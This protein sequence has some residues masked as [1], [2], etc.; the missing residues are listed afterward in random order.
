MVSYFVST[1]SWIDVAKVWTLSTEWASRHYDVERLGLHLHENG[2]DMSVSVAFASMLVIFSS[3]KCRSYFL[4][5]R[6][7]RSLQKLEKA[8]LPVL[9]STTEGTR[10]INNPPPE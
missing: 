4:N 10:H 6:A 2:G 8:G 9:T 5:K 1:T 7:T 3:F